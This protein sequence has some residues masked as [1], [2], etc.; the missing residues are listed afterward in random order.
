M[1]EQPYPTIGAFLIAR[2][3]S[4]DLQKGLFTKNGVTCKA[5]MA[6]YLEMKENGKDESTE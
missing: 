5:G 4:Y 2:Q 1:P 6:F 3:W